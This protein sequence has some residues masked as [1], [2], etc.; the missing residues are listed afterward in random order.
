MA[1]HKRIERRGERYSCMQIIEQRLRVQSSSMDI[2]HTFGGERKKKFSFYFPHPPSSFY[3]EKKGQQQHEVSSFPFLFVLFRLRR[4][5]VR[6]TD[7]VHVTCPGPVYKRTNNTQEWI[8]KSLCGVYILLQ[9]Q[10]D[11]GRADSCC[12]CA[13]SNR[14]WSVPA[15]SGEDETWMDIFNFFPR[16]RK[17]ME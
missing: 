17:K 9:D 4:L 6:I 1:S 5:V 14:P 15:V 2:Q 12:Y 3:F 11:G 7:S 16:I 10:G 8:S 13:L